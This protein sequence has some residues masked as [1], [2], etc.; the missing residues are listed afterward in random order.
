M[1]N[2]EVQ[3]EVS[4]EEQAR[5]FKK[6]Y[7]DIRNYLGKRLGYPKDDIEFLDWLKELEGIESKEYV[8]NVLKTESNDFD[9]IKERFDPTIIR[10]LHGVMGMATEAGEMLDQLKKVL[11]Y[12]KELDFVNLIEE[13]GDSSWYQAIICD[14]L[15]VEFKEIWKKNIAKLKARY[16]DKFN[17]SGALDRDLDN[18]RKI[19]EGKTDG[20]EKSKD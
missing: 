20:E 5:I 12:G 11:F 7:Y 9:A 13:M 3:Q 18:E 2:D 10:L 19:L 1:S 6:K 8:E 15:Q 17:E 16:G 4:V 14:E